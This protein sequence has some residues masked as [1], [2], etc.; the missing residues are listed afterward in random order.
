VALQI[1]HTILPMDKKAETSYILK[2]HT[3]WR[4][5]EWWSKQFIYV[6]Y[7]SVFSVIW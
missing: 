2:W 7:V 6:E 4:S 3:K 5:T 1:Y